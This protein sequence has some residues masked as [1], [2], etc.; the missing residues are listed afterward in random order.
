[1]QTDEE[2]PQKTHLE[3]EPTGEQDQNNTITVGHTTYTL[4]QHLMD[5]MYPD[6][7]DQVMG[8]L[9]SYDP[10]FDIL[11]LSTGD[12]PHHGMEMEALPD[13]IIAEVATD[14]DMDI[15]ALT[16]LYATEQLQPHFAPKHRRRDAGDATPNS[17]QSAYHPDTDTLVMGN[18]KGHNITSH[19]Q[20]H[21]TG[22]WKRQEP[23]RQ[24]R[25]S[26]LAVALHNASQILEPHF[27]F[28]PEQAPDSTPLSQD[29]KET[30]GQC[31]EQIQNS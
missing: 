30:P 5:K 15:I 18:P 4:S 10:E 27:Q 6:R 19:T 23:P 28:Q 8:L 25:V 13:E 11:Y 7:M 1:M 22:Y 12:P 29:P 9:V 24:D 17:P 3:A 16:V 21:I 26:L 20:P 14:G 2:P 31:Q